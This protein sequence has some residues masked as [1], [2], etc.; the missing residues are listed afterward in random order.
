[1]DWCVRGHLD[2]QQDRVDHAHIPVGHLSQ[3]V[4]GVLGCLLATPAAL[5][6]QRKADAEGVG[7]HDAVEWAARRL[8]RRDESLFAPVERGQLTLR[9]GP[10]MARAMPAM[11]QRWA[12][13]TSIY[14]RWE[15]GRDECAHTAVSME[16]TAKARA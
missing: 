8:Q 4:L 13:A 7:D 5:Q 6:G 9:D 15:L 1:M 12:I 16:G 3:A 11:A 10:T 14:F 2:R